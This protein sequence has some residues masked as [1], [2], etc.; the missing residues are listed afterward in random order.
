[1]KLLI[2]GAWN[3]NQ[4]DIQKL[5]SLGY[6]CFFHQNED[7]PLPLSFFDVDGVI[8]NGLF[9]YNDFT[10]FNKL[11][12]V[13]LTSAGLDRIPIKYFNE[14]NIKVFNAIG[15]YSTPISEYVISSVLDLYKQKSVFYRNQTNHKW[16]KQRN[17]VEL[18]NK[19]VCIV[20]CGNVGKECAKKFKGFDCRVIGVDVS[21]FEAQ[22]FDS[23]IP[24]NRL[25]EYLAISDIVVLT[26]PLTDKTRNLVDYSFFK[27][28]KRTSVL[29]NVARGAIVKTSDL[30][31]ALN[32]NTIGGAVLDVFET[33]PLDSKSPLWDMDNVLITPHNSFVGEGNNQRLSK[34]IILNLE[35][36]I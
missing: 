3:Y 33:E 36:Q 22:S 14:K 25:S 27:C 19:T 30:I 20:G 32:N 18:S 4:E 29:V 5:K 24:I 34:L 6:E 2:T 26:L 13:Q 31:D 15:V 10:K 28:M 16:I 1:M 21:S 11:K 12:F 23:I 17:I 9:L 7:E 8:C 35:K